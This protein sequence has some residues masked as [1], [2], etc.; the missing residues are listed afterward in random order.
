M[1]NDRFKAGL[2][3]KV[4]ATG[5]CWLTSY[6]AFTISADN[7]KDKAL[8]SFEKLRANP[9]TQRYIA[10]RNSIVRGLF[11]GRNPAA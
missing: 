10:K 6:T 9:K 5:Y 4:A 7:P 2:C 11:T 3:V 1:L 8:R